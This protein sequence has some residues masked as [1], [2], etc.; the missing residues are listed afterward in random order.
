MILKPFKIHPIVPRFPTVSYSFIHEH[1]T[2][3]RQCAEWMIEG[4]AHILDFQDV[5]YHLLIYLTMFILMKYFKIK[6]E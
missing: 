4:S 6:L 5:E 3:L 1:D 2:E